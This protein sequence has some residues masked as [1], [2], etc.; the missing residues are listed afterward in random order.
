MTSVLPVVDSVPK[1]NPWN[2]RSRMNIAMVDVMVKYP[3]NDSTKSAYAIMYTR[4]RGNMS[5]MNP[6]SGLTLSTAMT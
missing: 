6:A 1:V 5:A 2:I 3:R 4:L